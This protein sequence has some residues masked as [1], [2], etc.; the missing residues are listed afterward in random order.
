MALPVQR[1]LPTT[2]ISNNNTNNNSRNNSNNSN[3]N[4]NSNHSNN[5]N[6]NRQSNSDGITCLTLLAYYGLVCF[7]RAS[8]CQGSP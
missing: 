1:Y 5:S 7:M 3:N 4:N 2:D 8:W 6:S